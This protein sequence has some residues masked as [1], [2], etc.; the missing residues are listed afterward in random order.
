MIYSF[1]DETSVTILDPNFEV[2]TRDIA[3]GKYYRIFLDGESL[4]S[5]ETTEQEIRPWVFQDLNTRQLK[6][7]RTQNG[8]VVVLFYE[9]HTTID[10]NLINDKLNNI[11]Y[12]FSD[13]NTLNQNAPFTMVA[14]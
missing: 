7:I 3:D 13:E 4:A 2:I 8:N 11:L 1:N 10:I 6:T 9:G 12:Y 5:E 14:L